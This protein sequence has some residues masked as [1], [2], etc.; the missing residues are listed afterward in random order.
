MTI[1]LTPPLPPS[2]LTSS[3]PPYI[4]SSFPNPPSSS[5]SVDN[6]DADREQCTARRPAGWGHTWPWCRGTW[7]WRWGSGP[8]ARAW[9]KRRN[10]PRGSGHPGARNRSSRTVGF[11]FRQPLFPSPKRPP[12]LLHVRARGPP[13][14]HGPWSPSPGLPRSPPSAPQH[15]QCKL[16][17]RQTPSF[18]LVGHDCLHLAGHMCAGAFLI[19]LFFYRLYF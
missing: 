15:S 12:G 16:E 7:E 10:Q 14:P 6:A 18:V 1:P 2:F 3:V 4:L 17:L 8:M 13:R 5:S 19:F 11:L 9:N